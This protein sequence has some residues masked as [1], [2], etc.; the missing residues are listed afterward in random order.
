MYSARADWYSVTE[1]K[2]VSSIDL[3]PALIDKAASALHLGE[4]KKS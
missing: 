3:G 4:N 2:A 1:A